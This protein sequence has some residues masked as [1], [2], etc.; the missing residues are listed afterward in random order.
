MGNEKWEKRK[1]E[2]EMRPEKMNR[3]SLSVKK[4]K[5]YWNKPDSAF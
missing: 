2:Y 1:R 4:E 5:L 3:R